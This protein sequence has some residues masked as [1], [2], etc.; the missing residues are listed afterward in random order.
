MRAVATAAALIALASLCACGVTSTVPGT[1]TVDG[2]STSAFAR[3]GRLAFEVTEVEQRDTVG[4]P[5]DPGSSVTAKGVFVVVLLRVRNV[6]SEP[7][8]FVDAD[9]TLVDTTGQP[10][11]TDR[12]ANIYGNRDVPST[13]LAPGQ[14]LRLQLA[15]DVPRGTQ[16]REVVLRESSTSPGVV[17][18]LG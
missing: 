14:E 4:D 6:G 15:F 2:K 1:P 7:L 8:T 5:A 11:A 10:Y 17:V 12:A 3:D 13:R 16:P 9:Q 18:A